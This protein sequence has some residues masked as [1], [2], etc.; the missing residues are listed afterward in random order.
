MPVENQNGLVSD[1]KL[2]S[3]HTYNHYRFNQYA[4]DGNDY[5]GRKLTGVP[6]TVST[7]GVDLRLKKTLYANL[8][9]NYVDHVPL[10]DANTEYASKYFLLGARIG[11][12]KESENENGVDFFLGIDNALNQKYSLGNDLNA[13]GGRYYNAAAG[14][15][16]Y[17]GVKLSVK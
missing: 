12:K 8:T 11:L 16:F 14:I 1:L 17:G 7:F 10:N 15:N 2:W 6:P 9:S 5:S 4:P 13:L 3:S